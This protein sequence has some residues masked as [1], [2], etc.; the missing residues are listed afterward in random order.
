MFRHL[1]TRKRKKKD[2]KSYLIKT[3]RYEYKS[4]KKEDGRVYTTTQGHHLKNK[5][6]NRAIRIWGLKSK[7]VNILNLK[8]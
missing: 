4:L 7:P 1:W 6:N 5:V 3:I 8:E 2:K